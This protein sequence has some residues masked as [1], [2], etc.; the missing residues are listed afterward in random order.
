MEKKKILFVN[1]EMTVG[2]VARILCT[3]L[4]LI[5]REKYDVDLLVLHKHGD[6]LKE[7]P[8]DINVIE[9][10]KF[11]RTVDIPLKECNTSDILSKIVL[12]LSMKSGIIKEK[13]IKERKKILNKH[14]DIEFAAK[15]GFCTIFT[16]YGDSNK[17]INWVQTDYKVNNYAV[18]HM[19]LMKDA[20]KKIDINIACSNQVEKSFREIFGVENVC[21]IHNPIDNERIKRLSLEP[22]SSDINESKINLITVARF[23]PQKALHRIIKAYSK[24]KDYYSLTIVGDGVLKEELFGYAKKLGVFNDIKWCGFLKN[25]YN[26]IK[27]SELF[28]ISSLYE[29]YPT[30]TVESL[31]SGTP[32]LSTM[33]AGIEE[34]ISKEEYGFIIENND[35]AIEIS[36]NELKEKKGVL[37]KYK[38]ALQTYRYD[39]ESIIDQYY[40]LF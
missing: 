11:F 21:V 3:L 24:Y 8:N 22:L 7:I 18:H 29:G 9:G 17:K 25:P 34:Q 20:L 27:E 28:V 4:K 2:G 26:L 39:N 23:H 40:Q 33:V 1:D 19:N 16:A 5:D 36:L 10:T 15:E 38:H 35:D 12:L 6:L 13:I 32:I 14:Y 30:I 31:I 37:L